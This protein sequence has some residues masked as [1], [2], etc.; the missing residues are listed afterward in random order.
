[1]LKKILIIK[2]SSLGDVVQ[3]WKVLSYLRERLPAVQIDWVVERRALALVANHPLIDQPIVM[4]MRAWRKRPFARETRSC[5]GSFRKA[6][7]KEKYDVVF[8]LQGNVKSSLI[9]ALTQA[10]VKVGFKDP[11]EGINRLFT[12]RKYQPPPG[13]NIR[14][15]YL[16]L[17]QSFF[18]DFSQPI[19]SRVLLRRTDDEEGRLQTLVGKLPSAPRF[20]IFPAAFWPNKEISEQQLISFLE[21]IAMR[22]HPHFLFVSGSPAET[23][24]ALRLANHFCSSLIDGLSISELQGLIAQVNLVIAMDS[25]PLHLAATTQTPTFSLFGATQ[26]AAYAPQGEHHGVFQSPCP[27]GMRFE[28]RCP[29][30]RSCPTGS[31]LKEI[32][33]TALTGVFISWFESLSLCALEV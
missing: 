29:K 25:F 22:Y 28:M 2:T 10:S 1:M 15:R 5:F 30:L 13:I 14:D 12:H 8:D 20:L 31:C 3:G 21:A 33:V 27:Y 4:D 18:D 19:E 17:V 6:L 16:F 23:K 24:R 26:A 32:D 9:L 11:R 7:Q